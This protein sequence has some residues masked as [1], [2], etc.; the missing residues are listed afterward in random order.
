MSPEGPGTLISVKRSLVR[1]P[2]VMG[3]GAAALVALGG[4]N[5][6]AFMRGMEAP[7]LLGIAIISDMLVIGAGIVVAAREVLVAE[8]RTEAVARARGLGLL[9]RGLDATPA[10]VGVFPA[11]G[12][13]LYD[14]TGNVWE[15]TS[16]IFAERR[17]DAA[18]KACCAPRNPRVEEPDG[19]EAAGQPGG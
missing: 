14:V 4:T 18:G 3:A 11:N 5:V 2:A 10:T 8:R 7:W 13:E 1:H 15:W 6:V 12:Y 19:G 17:P 16:D 9:P